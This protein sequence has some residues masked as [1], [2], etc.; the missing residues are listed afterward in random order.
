MLFKKV[1]IDLGTANSLVYVSGQGIV[2]NE[3]TVVAVTIDDGKVVAVGNEA[4]KMLGRTPEMISALRPLKDGVIADYL[5]TEAMIKYFLLKALGRIFIFKPDVM[6]SVPSGVTSVESRAV[7]DAALAAGAKNAYLIPEPLAAA[8]GSKI[9][10]GRPY[11][12]MIVNIGGGTTE[13][14]IISLGG[15]VTS[16]SIRV[17]GNK[18]DEAITSFVRRQYNLQIGDVAAEK[19]KIEIGSA[20]TLDKKLTVEVKGRDSIGGLPRTIRLSSTEVAQAIRAP[21]NQI[22]G[23]IKQVLEKTPPELASDVMDK[24]M[25]L[26]GGSAL[27]RNIDKFITDET[28]VPAHIADNPLLCTVKGIGI[29]LENLDDF[30]KAIKKK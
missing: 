11:G 13:V 8:I 16:G 23:R 22:V 1:A 2:L 24:G 30:D 27:L 6:I 19:V 7:R 12:N 14:A 9:P 21:L 15:L 3:P 17:A 4:K 29:A 26:S 5:V 28:G 10:V 25:V 18:I 20:Y